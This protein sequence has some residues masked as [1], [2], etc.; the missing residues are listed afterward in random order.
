M[1]SYRLCV[2]VSFGGLAVASVQTSELPL[3]VHQRPP[4][5]C[6]AEARSRCPGTYQ[7]PA[8]I[9]RS[10]DFDFQGALQASPDGHFLGDIRQMT[11][12][13]EILPGS[14]ME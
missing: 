14:D 5:P 2:L 4:A 8:D 11:A 13:G 1:G 10:Y 12:G 9:C 7:K 3:I 6:D